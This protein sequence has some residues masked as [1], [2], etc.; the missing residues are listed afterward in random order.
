MHSRSLTL[1]LLLTVP[2]AS[3]AAPAGGITLSRCL[4]AHPVAATRVAARCGHLEVPESPDRPD[5]RKLLLH[6]AVIPADAPSAEPD[7][8]FVV[9]GGPGQAITEV[10]PQIAPAFARLNRDRDIVLVDQRGTGGSGRLA[11][12]KLEKAS[13]ELEHVRHDESRVAADCARSLDADLTQ[14]TTPAFVRDLDGVRAAL[15]YDRVNLV[16]FSYGTRASLAYAR[17]HPDRVRTLVLDGVAPF[18]MLVGADF[19]EDSEQALAALFRRCRDDA[20]CQARYPS[21][22]RD[23]RALLARLDRKPEKVRA[24]HPLTGEPLELTLDGDDV[25]QVVLGFLYGTETAALLPALLR[26]ARDGD[27]AALAA[28]GI[29]VSTDIQ[30]G[31]SRPLQLSVLCAED[32][33]LY[34]AEPGRR[35]ARAATPPAAGGARATF[36]GSATRDAFRKLCSGWPHSAPDAAFRAPQTLDVPALLLSGGADPVTPPRWAEMAARSLPRSRQ[37]VL[38]G[39]GHGVFARGCVPR[40]VTEFVK[41]AAPDGLDL[42][43]LEPLAPAPIFVDLQGSAP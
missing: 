39:Q 1:A 29:L 32:V 3:V 30:A 21:L 26:Q 17:A 10:Y 16:G 15:G 7:P 18:E 28:Q 13:A 27:L 20:A 37:V 14:Y 41:R 9:A 11:C 38:P 31:M 6:V 43:C 35:P 19:D 40:V 25:R 24:R 5:G 8:V 42:S 4:L 36:L 33:P 34:R 22:D 23:F 12:P 2:A